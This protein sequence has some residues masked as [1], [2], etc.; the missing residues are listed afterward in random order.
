MAK[1]LFPTDLTGAVG[2]I[3]YQRN[4]QGTAMRARVQPLNPQT[5]NQQGARQLLAALAAAWR[6]LSA[7]QRAAW[8]SF[9]A[10]MPGNPSGFN[11][12]VSCNAIRHNCADTA[13][14]DPPT[15]PAFGVMTSATPT[16]VIEDAVFTLNLGATSNTVAPD[17]YEVWASAFTSAGVARD[18]SGLRLLTVVTPANIVTAY[19]ITTPY[20]S[21][22]GVPAAGEGLDIKLVPIKNGFKGVGLQW[23][24]IVTET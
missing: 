1:K 18:E 6:G 23:R 8:S 20:T 3:V 17:K 15:F 7:N 14:T 21:R 2:D 19:A 22:F 11:C 13:Y 24:P 9:S 12:Y 10:G 16:A 4:R 5:N